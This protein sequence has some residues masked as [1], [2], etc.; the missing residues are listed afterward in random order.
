MEVFVGH[1][2]NFNVNTQHH[3]SILINNTRLPLI[4]SA[5]S[6][7]T[8]A[9]RYVSWHKIA[10]QWRNRTQPGSTA[11]ARCTTT[12]RMIDYTQLQ[13]KRAILPLLLIQSQT[14]DEMSAMCIHGLGSTLRSAYLNI[15]YSLLGYEWARCC[16]RTC[17]SPEKVS[18][19]LPA[20]SGTRVFE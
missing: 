10:S 3:A 8:D 1:T 11:I 2:D 9:G 6:C 17:R 16:K 5:L 15:S 14:S 12:P 19:F 18:F 4:A 7:G 20:W 13:T